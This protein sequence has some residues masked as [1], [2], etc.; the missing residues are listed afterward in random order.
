MASKSH[1]VY[2]NFLVLC[3]EKSKRER[4]KEDLK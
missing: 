1:L 4:V 3:T 2:N